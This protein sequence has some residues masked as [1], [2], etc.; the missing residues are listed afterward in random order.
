MFSSLT[1]AT[2]GRYASLVGQLAMPAA[3]CSTVYADTALYPSS[4]RNFAQISL[5][6]DNVFGDNSAAQIAQQTP[7]ITG[8]VAAGYVG[9]ATIGLAR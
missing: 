5:S 8:S 1:S 6:N 9:T 2:S 4:A 3:V 7:A